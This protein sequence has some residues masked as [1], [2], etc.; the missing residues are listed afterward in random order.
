MRV[1]S[2]GVAIGLIPNQRGWPWCEHCKKSGHKEDMFLDIQEKSS[3]WKPRQNSKTCRYQALLTT[4]QEN[5]SQVVLSISNRW[6][7]STKCFLAFNHRVEPL[8]ITLLAHQLIEVIFES[9]TNHQFKTP[10]IFDSWASDY[11]IDFHHLFFSYI[12]CAGNLKG[13]IVDGSLLSIA[14]KRCIKNSDFITL[15]SFMFKSYHAIYFL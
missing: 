2:K 3:N 4:K 1:Y 7:N 15:E 11:M 10:W 14:R 13:R 6:S 12:S 5:P 8:Q 9:L